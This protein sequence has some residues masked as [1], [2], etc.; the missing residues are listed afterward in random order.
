MKNVIQIVLDAYC[1]HNLERKIGTKDVTPFLNRLSK[2]SVSFSNMYSLAPY[3]EASH[4]TLLGG[5][6]T[7]ESGGYLFG[8]G[9]V[10][11][12]VAEAY[13]NAGY[14]TV[15]GYSPYVYS[16]AYLR[17]ID[18]FYYTRLYSFQPL[19]DYR[20]NYFRDKFMDSALD[21]QSLDALCIMLEEAFECW[22]L[23]CRDLLSHNKNCALI[24]EMISDFSQI[25]E[26][27]NILNTEKNSFLSD[28]KVYIH[29]LFELWKEHPLVKLSTMYNKRSQL[30]LTSYLLEKYSSSLVDWQNKWH[31]AL[32][33]SPLHLFADFQMV[34]REKEWKDSVRSL[35]SALAFR[36]NNLIRDYLHN[37]D[38]QSK[39]EASLFKM[40]NVFER[41]IIECDKRQEP[42]F[43]YFQP[44]DF[45]LP[46]VFHSFDCDDCSV[47]DEEFEQVFEL[48]DGLSDK[49]RGNL[50]ADLS[51]HYCDFRLEQFYKKLKKELKNEFLFVV[52]ADHGFPSYYN[53]PRPFIYNQTYTEAFH[54]PLIIN[55]NETA[56]YDG[57]YSSLDAVEFIK[58][59]AGIN[60]K[61]DI[62]S[63]E[64]ILCEYVG[65]GCPMINEKKIWYT[66]ITDSWKM[67]ADV[68]LSRKPH[69]GDIKS[70][71]N[72]KKD[73]MQ[74]FNLYRGHKYRKLEKSLL[75]FIEKRNSE[76]Q[77]KIPLDDF[78]Q[79]MASQLP[80]RITGGGINV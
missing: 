42:Y 67:S 35:R 61:K 4:I 46:S 2:D 76:L 79:F 5:E 3:T 40:L 65:P 25:E 12:P 60:H 26:I 56:R 68:P 23:Q 8:N 1:F 39:T 51:A 54:I 41:E 38:G 77:S 59:H 44:Q 48:M 33:K 17:N 72:L 43:L 9:T 29:K 55:G 32:K 73:S 37:L 11:H 57:L 22:L 69:W 27:I 71:Y 21:E 66:V 20:L 13:Q 10:S 24:E 45:H 18:R 16:K 75:N 52:T 6:N 74:L 36:K 28:R 64:Y 50:L 15:L 70:L 31:S 80:E 47:V 58:I 34:F 49:Y 7:L 78:C 30:P 53:P 63:H 19:M 14:T 62:P